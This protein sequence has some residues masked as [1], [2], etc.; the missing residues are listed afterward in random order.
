MPHE[1]EE[2]DESAALV[3]NADS[4]ID[5]MVTECAASYQQKTGITPQSAGFD[6]AGIFGTIMSMLLDMCGGKTAAQL[7]DGATNKGRAVRLAAQTA[8]RRA[9][10][11][12]HGLFAYMR[13]NGDAIAESFLDAAASK[14]EAHFQAAQQMFG[15]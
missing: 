14:S 6:A 4:T 2:P 13:F 10:R 12:R 7:K 8:T 15:A 9:L 11:E 1:L 3:L 5:Q